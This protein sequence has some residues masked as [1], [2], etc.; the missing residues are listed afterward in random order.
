[1]TEL[2][3]GWAL[4]GLL[5]AA[6]AY[7][8]GLP[9]ITWWLYGVLIWPV[10]LIH[11]FFAKP[12]SV[13]IA[14]R[15]Q[16]RACPHCAETVR[17]EANVCKHCGR[18]LPVPARPASR[19]VRQRESG[20][21]DGDMSIGGMVAIGA[22]ALLLV[23]VFLLGIW[24]M[25]PALA[26]AADFRCE[27][28]AFDLADCTDPADLAT[29]PSICTDPLD[30]ATCAVLP[31]PVLP[32]LARQAPDQPILRQVDVREGPYIDVTLTRIALSVSD[33]R[34]FDAARDRLCLRPPPPPPP[35]PAPPAPP[36][37]IRPFTLDGGDP[38]IRGGDP[39]IRGGDPGILI[40]R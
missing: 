28:Q 18:D 11:V 38:G 4:L 23:L 31:L 26:S 3:L 25:A 36:R 13:T 29:C 30:L 2:L 7:V 32:D 12:G 17:P 39:G 27:Q 5:P 9:F 1:M 14:V 40:R 10:A 20:W 22:G 35:P 24:W 16:E 8:R 19:A 33:D 34:V 37:V 15:A 6:I 21:W